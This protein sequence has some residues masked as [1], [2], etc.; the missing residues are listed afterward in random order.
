MIRKKFP[1]HTIIAVAH[2]LDTIMDFDKVAVLEAGALVECDSP[3][4]LLEN[5]GSAFSKLYNA[6]VTVEDDEEEDGLE[7]KE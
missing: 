7:A 6:T 1:G 4:T 3:Y 5:P 2:R